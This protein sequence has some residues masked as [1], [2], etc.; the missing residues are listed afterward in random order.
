MPPLETAESIVEVAAITGQGHTA[1]LLKTKRHSRLRLRIVVCDRSGQVTY[2]LDEDAT[3]SP[4]DSLFG[5]TLNGATLLHCLDDAILKQSAHGS[6]ILPA[7]A[8]G[9]SAGDILH[10]HP[11]GLLIQ[12]PSRLYLATA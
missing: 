6:T 7:P 9:L 12:Q 1:L 8:T 10:A 11:A 4:F 3:I 5:K 2:S